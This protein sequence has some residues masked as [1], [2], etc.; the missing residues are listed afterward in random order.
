MDQLDLLD[1][2]RVTEENLDKIEGGDYGKLEREGKVLYRFRTK[3]YRIYFEVQD[4]TIVVQRLLHKNSFSDFL[5][6]SKMP[7]SEDEALS[8]SKHFWKLIDEGRN[9]R[10]M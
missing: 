7:V 2:F 1:S 3:D 4:G 8:E 5:F 10:K 9:A 6:R